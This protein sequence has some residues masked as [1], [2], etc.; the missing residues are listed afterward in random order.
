[1]K[2][3]FLF[4][5]AMLCTCA[6]QAVT[7]SWSG[8]G[9]TNATTHTL[10]QPVD[11]T[12]ADHFYI[13][14]IFEEN[15]TAMWNDAT[16]GESRPDMIT[17]KNSSGEAVIDLNFRKQSG[18]SVQLNGNDL[19]N[20]K[21]DNYLKDITLVFEATKTDGVWSAINYT[22]SGTKPPPTNVTTDVT[23]DVTPDVRTF[24]GTLSNTLISD[25]ASI[26]VGGA[27]GDKTFNNIKVEVA[28][29]PE[30]T[31]LALLALGVAGLALKR[32][33]A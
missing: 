6:V 32:K 3:A 11:F 12:N 33:V 30:P 4:M 31:A 19:A 26:E 10:S 20:P 16:A 1:M 25:I 9:S 22:I 29:V 8:A 24:T 17:L 13:S 14:I 5:L 21:L 27:I 28:N 18:W 7:F 23:P 2:K 15:L